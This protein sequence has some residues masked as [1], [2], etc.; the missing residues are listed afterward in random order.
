MVDQVQTHYGGGDDLAD[1]IAQNLQAAGKN[2]EVLK[3]S[4]LSTVD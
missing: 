2:L 3:T 4:D 1:L